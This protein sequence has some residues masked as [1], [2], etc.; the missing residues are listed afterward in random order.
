MEKADGLKALQN[1]IN[2]IEATIKESDGVFNI[3][4]AVSIV[5]MNS[6]MLSNVNLP[7][8]ILNVYFIY[9]V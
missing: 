8:V 3:L 5:L 2:K 9:F 1:A 4:T 6:F 7:V